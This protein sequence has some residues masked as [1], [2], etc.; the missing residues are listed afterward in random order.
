VNLTAWRDDGT[1]ARHF[2]AG[3]DRHGGAITG[4]AFMADGTL[5]SA[6]DRVV[7]WDA[8][9]RPLRMLSG[10]A[11]GACFSATGLAATLEAT[12][13]RTWN[14][15]TGA[16]LAEITDRRFAGYRPAALS[17]DGTRVALVGEQ[18]IEQYL[19]LVW[20]NDGAVTVREPSG[21]DDFPDSCAL[22]SPD[23]TTLIARS[24]D[25][26]LRRYRMDGRRLVLDQTIP[27]AAGGGLAV[28]PSG[29]FLAAQRDGY[30]VLGDDGSLF[31][32]PKRPP[33]GEGEGLHVVAAEATA[34]GVMVAAGGVPSGVRVWLP[35]APKS[36]VLRTADVV[37][38]L[39]LTGEPSAA[40]ARLA[41]GLA[42]GKIELWDLGPSPAEPAERPRRGRGK[43][44]ASSA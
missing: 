44:A 10:R 9:G 11:D 26:R 43:Q 14:M 39:A 1:H 4:L 5:G 35:G 18:G 41:V 34:D 36:I 20:T 24:A 33:G 27:L 30:R 38:A 23:E 31:S 25:H 32:G 40:T 29:V 3:V 17:R 13:L 28:L 6:A 7:Q 22:F 19:A 12:T 2:P 37:T 42:N 21:A 8:L 15:A 16:C